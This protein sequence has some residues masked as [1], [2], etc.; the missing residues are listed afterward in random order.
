VESMDAYPEW[1]VLSL[2]GIH[3]WTRKHTDFMLLDPK[4]PLK[5]NVVEHFKTHERIKLHMDQAKA[6][7]E[8]MERAKNQILTLMQNEQKKT[9]GSQLR[10]T[11]MARLSSLEKATAGLLDREKKEL[12][13]CTFLPDTHTPLYRLGKKTWPDLCSQLGV[14]I[15][16]P[17]SLRKIRLPLIFEAILRL[18]RSCSL[19]RA[20]FTRNLIFFPLEQQN[21]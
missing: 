5:T 17:D 2:G 3:D 4:R 6:N 19:Q 13:L 20:S 16:K 12:A 15:H 21:T 7:G 18:R 14:N 11:Q 1:M 8:D 10:L 9:G